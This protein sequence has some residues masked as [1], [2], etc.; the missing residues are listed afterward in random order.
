MS[1]VILLLKRADGV[2]LRVETAVVVLALSLMVTLKFVDVVLRNI[3]RGGVPEFATIAQH[4]VIWVG[5]LGA[6]LATAERKHI[7]IEVFAPVLTP[8]GRRV[9]DGVIDVAAMLAS[10]F[11]AYVAWRWIEFS[12]RPD[13]ATVFHIPFLDMPF[14]RWWSLTI[15]P[16]GFGLVALRFGRLAL[17]RVFVDEP[18]DVEA[19]RR[20]EFADADRRYSS[21]ERPGAEEARRP[22]SGEPGDAPPDAEASP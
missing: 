18:V 20:R 17:E 10:A 8:S 6:S 19:E 11:F 13:P 22:V 7:A 15:V 4:L 14:R 1:R 2:L 9:V 16:V 12:E 21:A 3:G 5:M